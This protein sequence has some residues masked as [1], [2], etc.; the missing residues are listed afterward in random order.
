MVAHVLIYSSTCDIHSFVGRD[1]HQNQTVTFKGILELIGLV[2]HQSKM[3]P[4]ANEVILK[5]EG[6]LE[7]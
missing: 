1:L 2:V 5:L 7:H 3:E 6:L 4:A